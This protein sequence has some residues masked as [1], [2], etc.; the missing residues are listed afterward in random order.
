MS[1]E[2]T[3]LERPSTDDRNAWHTY[4]KKQGQDWRIESEIDEQRQ[5]QLIKYRVIEPD[6]KKG[7]YPFR[8]IKLSRSD[9]EWLLATHDDGHG[10][11][12]WNYDYKQRGK[13]LDLRGANLRSVDLHGLP[14][15][16]IAGGLSRSD[17]IEATSEERYWS[18]VHLERANLS[19]AHLEGAD[20]FMAHLQEAD[21]SSAYLQGADLY[22]AHMEGAYLKD[23][24]LGGASIRRS[25]LDATTNFN[26]IKLEDEKLGCLLLG[27]VNW[28]DV[29]LSRANWI[30]I[31]MLGDE[32]EARRTTRWDGEVKNQDE[33]LDFYKWA[34]RANRQLAVALQAQGL[35]EEAAK[36]A[37]RSHVLQRIV[38]WQLRRFDQYLFSLFLSSVAGYGYKL[39]RSFA[40][41]AI[42]ILVFALAYH[43]FGTITGITLSPTEAIVFSMTSFHGRGF[44]PGENIGLSNPLTILA[45]IEALLGLIIEVTLIATLTQR[46]FKK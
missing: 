13:G 29:N 16:C 6:I 12:N 43:L 9:I 14:L 11:I 3:S 37:Y 19:F 2:L 30:Q 27:D 41:Y 15:A 36:F 1:Q 35:N 20:L 25:F 26:D 34:V 4:W 23:A 5:I 17:A 7:I 46:F 18:E 45:A 28:R 42:V 33:W 44:S 39:W 40:A 10:P 32:M 22:G 21:L 38:F 8:D 31:K 24:Y